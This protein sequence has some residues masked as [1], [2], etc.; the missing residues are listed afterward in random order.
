MRKLSLWF[1]RWSSWQ[2]I[3]ITTLLYA[4]FI[5]QVM[6][7]HSA[8]MESFAGQWGAPDGHIFYTPDELYAQVDTW[9]DAGRKHYIDF[10][11]GLDPLWA[12][13]YTSFLIGTISVTLKRATLATDRRRLLNLLPLAPMCADLTENILGIIIMSAYPDRLDALAW[14]TTA[15]SGFKWITLGLAHVV[16]LY[17]L[18]LLAKSL[19]QRA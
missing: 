16:L 12:L 11:L 3:V 5:S 7:P 15:T 8:L 1:Y 13:V 19:L 4:L 6:V 9:G 2:T 14:L 18:T 17:A 10:R